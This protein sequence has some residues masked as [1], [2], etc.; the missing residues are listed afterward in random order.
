MKQVTLKPIKEIVW[1]TDLSRESKVCVPY[2]RY[3]NEA[4]SVNNHAV[5]VLPKISDWVYEKT[6]FATEDFFAEIKQSVNL[7]FKKVEKYCKSLNLDFK[8]AVEQGVESEEILKYAETNE[9]DLLM[10]GKKG[11]SEINDLII[12]STT[13]RIIRNSNTPVLV[14]TSLKRSAKIKKVLCPID[15]GEL[16]LSELN[17]SLSVAEQFGAELYTAHISEFFNYKVPVFKRDKLIESINTKIQS[18]ASAADYSITDTLY[19]MG[20]PAQ[21]I[22]EIAKKGKFDLIVMAAN[23]KHGAERLFLGSITEKVLMNSNIPILI[24]PPVKYVQ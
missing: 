5:Y 18:I 3:F 23:Q 22:L 11:I 16:S 8:V 21:K 1:A 13:S 19:D 14:V 12:G 4:L 2:I 17:Y 9:V 20:E 10:V 7:S 15:F 24:I 6:F